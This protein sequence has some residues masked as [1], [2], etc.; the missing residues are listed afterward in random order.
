MN[1]H[2]KLKLFKKN[3]KSIQWIW[4]NRSKGFEQITVNDK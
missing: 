2:Y 3:K 4:T 1:G